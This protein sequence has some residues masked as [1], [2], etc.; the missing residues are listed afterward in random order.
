MSI[1]YSP[2]DN[3]QRE[4]LTQPFQHGSTM[5]SQKALMVWH[6]PT[7]PMWS[8]RTVTEKVT[9]K[10]TAGGKGEEKRVRDQSKSRG[11]EHVPKSGV[12]MQ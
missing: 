1:G 7:T 6:P 8:V 4:V 10:A 3:H 11:E 2:T 12:Q 9:I 5:Q